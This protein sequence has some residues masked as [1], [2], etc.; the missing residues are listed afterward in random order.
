FARGAPAPELDTKMRKIEVALKDR[1]DVDWKRNNPET[2]ARANDM[3]AQLRE[4][5]EGF[6][7]DLEKAREAGD[8]KAARAAQEA[9]DAR[10][11]WLRAIGS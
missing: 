6:Q 10:T 11:A 4:S 3:E 7:K 2:K 1:E 8:D 5:L 9:I